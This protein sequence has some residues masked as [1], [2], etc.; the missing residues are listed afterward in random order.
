M[1]DVTGTVGPALA[2]A[3]GWA[4]N[5]MEVA[6]SRTLSVFSPAE[7]VASCWLLSI[8]VA[9]NAD[10]WLTADDETMPH[11][12]IRV[13]EVARQVGVPHL[14]EHHEVE[15]A[16][17]VADSFDALAEQVIYAMWVYDRNLGDIR[18]QDELILGENAAASVAGAAL[19]LTQLLSHE[20]IGSEVT[21]AEL[22]AAY[23][24]NLVEALEAGA[25]AL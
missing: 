2:I 18:L 5:E 16:L 3:D 9:L 15:F 10:Q 20:C 22:V 1:S 8:N 14:A 23:Q 17:Q 13:A 25:G 24:S 19:Y 6:L 4:R 12:G 21:P 7:V 11:P